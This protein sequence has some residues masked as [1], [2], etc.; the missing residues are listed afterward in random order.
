MSEAVP[1]A[2]P[3]LRCR[4]LCKTYGEGESHLA[5]RLARW[6]EAANPSVATY[7]KRDGVHVRVAAKGDDE[8]TARALLNPVAEAVSDALH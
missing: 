3:V 4:G 1:H 2:G 8:G 6:T 5:E 7:A